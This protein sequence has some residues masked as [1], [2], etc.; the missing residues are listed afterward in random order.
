MVP[1]D[2]T[3]NYDK[4]GGYQGFILQA[5]CMSYIEEAILVFFQLQYFPVYAS[6]FPLH[7]MCVRKLYIIGCQCR[8]ISTSHYL[9]IQLGSTIT[10]FMHNLS[11][12]INTMH[13]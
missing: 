11:H 9:L 5:A 12:F 6:A 2:K 13:N 10:Y 7:A 1:Y 4:Q 8:F 3:K